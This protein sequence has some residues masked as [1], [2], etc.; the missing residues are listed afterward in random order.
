MNKLAKYLVLRIRRM[1][2]RRAKKVVLGSG[3]ISVAGWFAT[4]RDVL[5]LSDPKIF[6]EIW[7]KPFVSH[8]VAEHVWEHLEPSTAVTAVENCARALVSGGRL[9]IAVPDGRHPDSKYVEAVRPGGNGPGANDHKCLYTLESLSELI[10]RGS[11]CPIPLEWWDEDGVFH[12]EDWDPADG[13]CLE[14]FSQ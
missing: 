11:L 6:A 5:D 7:P 2:L 3:G 13:F 1:R 4:D 10:R 14:K 8:F 9:R 12:R